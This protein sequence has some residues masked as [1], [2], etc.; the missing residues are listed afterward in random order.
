MLEQYAFPWLAYPTCHRVTTTRSTTLTTTMRVIYRVHHHTTNVGTTTQPTTTASLTNLDILLVGVETAPW[1][2][3]IQ[4]ALGGLLQTSNAKWH[5]RDHDQQAEY[6]CRLSALAAPLTGLNSTLW[7][8]VPTGMWDN[9]KRCPALYQ[10]LSRHYRITNSQT[11]GSNNVALHAIFISY[12]RDKGCSIRI[13]LNPLNGRKHSCF[14]A[15]KINQAIPALVPAT[16]LPG[17]HVT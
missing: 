6:M 8:N 13:I 9:G 16:F 11:L 15:F 17:R 4:R 1:T 12:Q 7:I 14:S 5:N 2:P 3:C 10:P